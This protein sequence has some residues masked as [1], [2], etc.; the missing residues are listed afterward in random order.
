[1]SL[2]HYIFR[3]LIIVLPATCLAGATVSYG[4]GLQGQAFFYTTLFTSL[5]GLAVGILSACLNHK[6]FLAPMNPI[7]NYLHD[8][9]KGSMG[10]RLKEEELGQLKSIA[11]SINHTVDSWAH[12]LT[13]IQKA[14]KSINEYSNH[15]SH[16]VRQTTGAAE[17][18]SGT[19]EEAAKGAEHQVYS[20]SEAAGLIQQVT[21]SLQHVDQSAQRVSSS[22]HDTLDKA[23]MGTQSIGSAEQQMNAIFTNVSELSN[24][25]KGL[26]VRSSEIGNIVEVIKGIAE[27]TNLLALNAAIEAARAGEHGKGFAVVASEVRKLAEQSGEATQQISD[28]IFHIQNETAQVV[29]TMDLVNAEVSE[30]IGV[31]NDAG[32][33]F[34]QI[35]N[36]I[37][38]VTEHISQVSGAVHGVSAGNEQAVSSMDTISA[39][40]AETAK[41]SQ[42]VLA[43]T[44][45]QLASIEEMSA[46]TASLDELA[47]EME[48]LTHTFTM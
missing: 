19:M 42:Q 47:K 13:V 36:S 12:V 34:K 1:M 23:N 3:T 32:S 2:M 29:Q 5:M 26:G 11:V 20:V 35:Q 4:N 45:E 44:Q 48:E 25:V 22:I 7:N 21:E 15:L 33:S 24:T 37:Q 8:L 28:I 31:M 9:A 40:A 27:Q 16:G 6:R 17:Q 10:S 38:S 46:Y 14:S 41:S 30:G 18:I 43:A 39:I